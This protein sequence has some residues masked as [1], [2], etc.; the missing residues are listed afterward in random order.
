MKGKTETSTESVPRG[1][2]ARF[3]NQ[4]REFD[5]YIAVSPADGDEPETDGL[6]H[7]ERMKLEDEAIELI[8]GQESEPRLTVDRT[9]FKM[10]MGLYADHWFTFGMQ[11]ADDR[12]VA[13]QQHLFSWYVDPENVAVRGSRQGITFLSSK[14]FDHRR[15][16][17]LRFLL[18]LLLWF[19]ALLRFLSTRFAFSD[20]SLSNRYF[21]Y[22]E[23]SGTLGSPNVKVAL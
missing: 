21:P 1:S 18:V 5:L 19:L 9:I 23:T 4:G 7:Q 11:A 17:P 12:L 16:R 20:L 13:D 8:I 3:R 22:W 6:T 14:A 10:R 2:E 15:R